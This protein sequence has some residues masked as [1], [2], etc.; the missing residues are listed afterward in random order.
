ME[1]SLEYPTEEQ[2]KAIRRHSGSY[3]EL[4]QMAREAYNESMGLFVQEGRHYRLATGGW[5]GNEDVI[6]ALEDS[7]GM[8]WTVCWQES[9]RGGAYQFEIPEGLS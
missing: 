6:D 9:K 2:L 1:G 5:S 7:E 3:I 4:M 8:F